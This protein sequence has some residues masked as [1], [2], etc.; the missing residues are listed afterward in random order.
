[1]AIRIVRNEAGNCINFYGASNPTHWNACLSGEVDSVDTNA[2]NVINDIITAETGVTQYEFFRIP[3]TEFVDADGNGFADAQSAADYITE[4][5]NVI[6]LSGEGIDLTGETV[7]FSLDATSTSIMIDNGYAFGV[8][9]IKAIGHADG[10]IHIV[11][12]DG[13]D[14]ITHFHH[15][16][17]GNTC[18]N[19][20]SVSGGLNDV[21]NSLNELFTVGAFEAVVIADPYSTMVADVDGVDIVSPTYIGNSI[22][23][24]GADVF[25]SS[26]SGNLNGYL[27]TETIDQ[28]GEYFTFDIRV[29]GTIGFGLVHSQASY[30]AGYYSGNATYANPA[31]FGT[32]NS[33]HGGFQFS[34]WFHPTPNGSWTNYG[35]NTSYSIRSGWSNFN[36]TDEQTDWLAGNPIKVRVGLDANGFISIETLRNG[37]DWVV[38][39]RT[40]YPSV[41]GVEYRLGIKMGDTNVRLHTLPKV[42]L[43]EP[44]APTMYFRYIESPDSN[45]HYPLFATAEEA[46]YYDL[47]NGGTGTSTANVFPDEPTFAQWYIPTNGYTN[48]GTSAPTS[49]ILFEGNPINWTEVTSLT[50]ADLVPSAFADQTV[51]VNELS[52]V[53]I[54]VTPA[55]ASYTTTITDNDSSGLTLIGANVEGTAP[56]VTGDNV[57]NPS[58]TYTITVTHTNSYGSSTGTLTIIVN[59]LTAPVTAISGFNHVSGT[60]AMIDADTM[61]DGSVVHVNTT[62]ADGERFVI[63]RAYVEAN[64]LP[65]LNATN[66]MYIIGLAN[67]PEDFSTLELSDFDTAIVWEYETASSHT[68]KFYRDGSVVQNIVVNSM[69]QAFYDYAI[70]IN[71]TSAWLIACNVNSIMNEPSPADGGNF[72]NTYEATS[73][74]DTAPVTIHMATLN[75]SGDISTTDLTTL[76]TPAAP[77]SLTPW[78]KALDFS[79]SNEH[80][81]Q[82][83]P[84]STHNAIRM[85]GM[86]VQVPV[87][88][89]SNKTTNDTNARPWACAIVFKSDNNSSNQHI[90]NS[91]EGTATG[92]DN[93]YLRVDASSNLYFG[94]GREGSGYNECRLAQNIS[95]SN[96]YGVYIAHK[97]YRPSGAAASAA[98]LSLGFDIRL[99]SSADSFN[100]VGSNLAVSSNWTSTGARMDRSVLGNFT[101]GGRGGNR[102]FHGKVA[103]MVICTLRINIDIPTDTEIKM[104]ITDPKKWE[105]DYRD[106]QFVRWTNTST[107]SNYTPSNQNIGY[108]AVQIWLMGDGSSDSYANGIRNEVYP[109]DQNDTK[110]Q[111]NSMVSND[112]QNVT[113][114]GLS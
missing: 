41:E 81:K 23:P 19:G 113:I 57:A 18:I 109:S 66:D 45:F 30:D 32:Y 65:S 70:E 33:Q 25:G 46:N 22:D 14:D 35:A 97:G 26:A 40:S 105:D 36:G 83:S 88:A 17:A 20:D 47:Q 103:S 51:T 64:I 60:T 69:T 13:A 43:L 28:A 78:T 62:V 73:I 94:W 52:A 42:H 2:V 104:M 4:K 92:N 50:N 34:H 86:S 44:A 1:M 71:G 82:V 79:G 21:V 100:A 49:A 98:N 96:W 12:N 38:H 7:C 93:I 107:F 85:G 106:G 5:A 59:N 39:V 89:D 11:S 68:F 54:Q 77:T 72:S 102:N 58:D 16:D 84:S 114:N 10:T 99:M 24:V 101:I 67:Q 37:T 110:L 15:L 108:G 87:N 91:G 112:I 95:S 74:E 80:A 75:T 61:D 56:E 31:N 8:N 9:T 111:L 90:W 48:N 6:G 55:D 63:E 76:T 53:N 3:Y 29:E 27:S